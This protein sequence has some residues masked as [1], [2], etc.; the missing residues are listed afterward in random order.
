[1]PPPP[2]RR[3]H[4]TRGSNFRHASCDLGD[5]TPCTDALASYS[6][7]PYGASS[8][9]I[10]GYVRPDQHFAPGKAT[11]AQVRYIIS[12]CDC[13]VAEHFEKGWREMCKYAADN[14]KRPPHASKESWL[15]KA[16]VHELNE[17][18]DVFIRD[19]IAIVID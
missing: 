9:R 7:A 18:V 17:A 13:A 3:K 16:C 14:G 4:L 12:H 15:A 10:P 5:N 19:P 11:P 2:S 6:V 1:M 8:S